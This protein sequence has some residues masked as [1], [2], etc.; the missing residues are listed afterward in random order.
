MELNKRPREWNTYH[1]PLI[2]EVEHLSDDTWSEERIYTFDMTQEQIDEAKAW[3]L[4]DKKYHKAL[5][6]SYITIITVYQEK[7]I[8]LDE[9]GT[10]LDDL[11]PEA[12]RA[13][14]Q[15]AAFG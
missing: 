9:T 14:L 1:K 12:L 13:N 5:M 3:Y 7:D 4:K 10:I 6:I 11:I 15:L 2:H 8:D